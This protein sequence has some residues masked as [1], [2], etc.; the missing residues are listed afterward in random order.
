MVNESLYCLKI[1]HLRFPEKVLR[2][3][4]QQNLSMTT[5][6]PCPTVR[7]LLDYGQP[8]MDLRHSPIIPN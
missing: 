6:I 1:N 5:I 3:D 2:M 7:I 8:Y 4:Y